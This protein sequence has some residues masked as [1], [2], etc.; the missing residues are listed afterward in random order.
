VVLLLATPALTLL[1]P[2]SFG[3][4]EEEHGSSGPLV[5]LVAAADALNKAHV[6]HNLQVSKPITPVEDKIGEK[7][8]CHYVFSPKT[9]QGPPLSSGT[10]K[11]S[12]LL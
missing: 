12:S 4:G 10:R 2:T 11:T 7:G 6:F 8:H 9:R 5:A 1:V 3:N